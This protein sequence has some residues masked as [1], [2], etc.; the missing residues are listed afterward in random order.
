LFLGLGIIWMQHRGF[1]RCWTETVVAKASDDE[2]D[3]VWVS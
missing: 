3:G 2:V 1:S